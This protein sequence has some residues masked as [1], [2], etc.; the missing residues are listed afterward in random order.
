MSVNMCE[1]DPEND[2][3]HELN[4]AEEAFERLCLTESFKKA[5]SDF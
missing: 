4:D 1:G 2:L 3:V 5:R